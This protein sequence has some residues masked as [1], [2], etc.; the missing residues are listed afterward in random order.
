[1]H[2]DK[3]RALLNSIQV[4]KKEKALLENLSKDHKRS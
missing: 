1:M 2:S 3:I 4:L